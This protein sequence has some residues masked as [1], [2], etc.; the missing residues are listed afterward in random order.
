MA[1]AGLGFTYIP[2]HSVTLDGLCVQ[3]LVEPEITRQIQIVTVRGRPHGQSVGAFVSEALRCPWWS[4]GAT[5][6]PASA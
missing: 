6:L 1:L 3:P 4:R 2:E 5:P